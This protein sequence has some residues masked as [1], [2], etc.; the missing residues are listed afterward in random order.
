MRFVAQLT[1]PKPIGEVATSGTLGPWNKG[2]AGATAIQGK[3]RFANADLSSLRELQGVLQSGGI[4]SGSI[5]EIHATGSADI[6]DFTLTGRPVSLKTRYDVLVGGTTGDVVLQPVEVAV[7]ES[8]LTSVGAVV[9][10]RDVKGRRIDMNVTAANAKIE[11]ILQLALKADPSPLSGAMELATNLLIEPSEAPVIRRLRLDGRFT[12]RRAR[13]ANTDIQK[14]RARVSRF[15]GGE[16]VEGENG[17]GVAA[18][19]M[20]RFTMDDGN[21]NFSSISFDVPGTAVKLAGSY[22]LDDGALDLRGT[23]RV[24]RSVADVAP[25]SAAGWLETLGRLDRRLQIDTSGTTIP[26]TIQGT[27]ENPMFRVDATA[28]KRNWRRAIGVGGV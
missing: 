27:R 11:D 24:A 15:T 20:G 2:D 17:S 12:I 28:L 3:F 23:I 1:N 19:L 22:R 25:P 14:T 9:R 8:E 18:N 5:A 26:V 21:L 4:Y 7:G 10:A 6:A 16:A 13:F